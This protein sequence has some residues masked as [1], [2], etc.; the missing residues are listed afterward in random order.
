MSAIIYA[1]IDPGTRLCRYV[2]KTK[3][4]AS[5]RLKAHISDA[6][7]NNVVPRFR[8]ISRLG[9]EGM[10]PEVIELET[11]RDG[12]WQE[13]EQ[14]WISY[15]RAIGCPLLNATAG[16]DGLH[17]F[18]H[19]AETRQKM[20]EAGFRTNADPA[21]REARGNGV[22]AAYADPQARAMLSERLRVSHARESVKQKLRSAART[23]GQTP[24]FKAM[25]SRTHT[26]KVV[27]SETRAKISAAR[28]GVKLSPDVVER[29]AAGHRGLRHSE[30][31][32][33][34]MRVTWARKKLEA[35]RG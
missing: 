5:G 22:R 13:A 32:K 19:S 15:M 33:A 12:Q 27:S 28:K 25:V 2:G 4:T 24:E 35:S 9:R 7:R 30:E 20:S 14:F 34:K 10:K 31:T 23:K 17:G 3:G 26:G 16:G 1:L 18:A 21:I 8:W 29:I 6:R 11:V